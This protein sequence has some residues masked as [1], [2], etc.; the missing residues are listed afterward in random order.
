VGSHAG[1]V[2]SK[3]SPA[4]FL[5]SFGQMLND[6]DYKNII[7]VS[8]REQNEELYCYFSKKYGG[9]PHQESE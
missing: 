9:L 2:L 7:C 1:T 4:D 6:V 5:E 3:K 8:K